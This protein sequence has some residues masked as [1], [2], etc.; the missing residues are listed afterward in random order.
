MSEQEM[1]DRLHR[2]VNE[3]NQALRDAYKMGI[4]TTVDAYYRSPTVFTL[5]VW[6]PL[7]PSPPTRR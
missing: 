3:L 2:L 1:A 7:D 4:D 6:K 5:K